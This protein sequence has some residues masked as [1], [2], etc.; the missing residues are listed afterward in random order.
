MDVPPRQRLSMHM[1]AEQRL[2]TIKTTGLAG[3]MHRAFKAL[4]PASI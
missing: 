4:V 1:A 2:C 3:G